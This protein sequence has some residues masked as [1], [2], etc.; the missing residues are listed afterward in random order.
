MVSFGGCDVEV[1]DV[2]D[3]GSEMAEAAVC[4]DL[5]LRV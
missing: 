5:A 4:D 3:G 1:E 2:V